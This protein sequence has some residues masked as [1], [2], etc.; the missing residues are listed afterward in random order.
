MFNPLD[1]N[2]EFPSLER[3]IADFWKKN[4][5]QKKYLEKNSSS[6]KKFSFLDGPIT[7]NNPMGVH[8]AW[9]RTYKDVFQRFHNLL[10]DK[11]RFQNGFDCQ[12]LWVEVEVEKDLGFKTKKDIESYGIA[13]F[14]QA[15]KDRANK[16]AVIQTEQSKRLGYFMDWGNDYITMSN[17]NNYAIWYFLKTCWQ[18][19]FLYKGRDSVPWCPRCGTA[20][21]Q[22]EISTEEYGELTHDSIFFELPLLSK[23][24]ER[25]LVWTTTPWTLPANVAVAINPELEYWQVKGDSG[26]KYWLVGSRAKELFGENTSPD[27]KELG[28]FL[29]GQKYSAP[30]DSLP[31]VQTAFLENPQTFHTVIASSDLV[32]AD[33]GTG[34][35]HIAPG[36]GAEDFELGKE[37]NLPVLSVIDESACYLEGLGDLSGKNAKD[38]P[39]L[40]LKHP[41]LQVKVGDLAQDYIFS[42]QPFTHRYP[43]CW[44]CKEELV[45]RVVDEWYIGM[46]RVDPFDDQKRTLRQQII[47]STNQVKTWLPEFGLSRELDWLNNMHDWLISKKRYWGLALPIWECSCGHFEV[48][49]SYEELKERA[50]E[51]WEQFDGKSPHRPFIDI[52]KVN[53][54]KCGEPMSR[55]LDVGNPWLDAGIVGFSTLKYFSD[56]QYWQE[57]FPA[58]LV[59]ECFPGQFRNWFYSLLAMSTVLERQ[60]PFKALVGHASVKDEHGEEMHKSK[61][62]AIWFD[63]A[64][65]KMGAD[66]MRWI[67]CKQNPVLD[68]HFGYL[69]A[70]QTRR[71]FFLILW[72]CY[73]F[74]TTYTNL[75]GFNNTTVLSDNLS[76]LDRWL[77]SRLENAVTVVGKSLST[78]DTAQAISILEDFVIN[79]FSTWYI[80]LSRDRVGPSADNQQDKD[81][82]YQTTYYVLLNLLKILSPFIPFLTEFL[83]QVIK[84]EGSKV[85]IHLEDWPVISGYRD[86]SLEEATSTARR[87][88]EQGR[89][90]RSSAGI[91]LK[92]PLS[93][94]TITQ[95]VSAKAHILSLAENL[96]I[97]ETLKK[98]LNVK[99]VEFAE[100]DQEGI[101][102][103]INL[104][105]ALVLEGRA[106]ELIREIQSARKNLGCNFDDYVSVTYPPEWEDVIRSD[107]S[108]YIK[109]QA[110]VGKFSAGLELLVKVSS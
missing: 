51:G 57:W 104:T 15:C 18:K 40:I 2:P 1:S 3:D 105:D 34:L 106:R 108:D 20:I 77:L 65:E 13:E 31:L 28:S 19:G 61:G 56:R 27:K 58:D 72:N 25:L 91:K 49:G 64:V 55:V 50:I 94:V 110:L 22:H 35:V 59:T 52:V 33:E 53:C 80:R 16:Y 46:D 89:A 75:D 79:D 82:F 102:L 8:H 69:L 12:G 83:W 38:A 100:A 36:C 6:N 90:A 99:A 41:L 63:D 68:L 98:E 17:E 32:K 9:G 54:P 78:Y 24:N 14:V 70:D 66:I 37:E 45:W 74:F 76:S 67:Y 21:S 30:F 60:A 92:Q 29:V 84:P 39:E 11:Q 48:I 88:V 62:N 81:S 87:L 4:G 93:K 101:I 26:I 47:D 95:I 10:G 5:I 71:Q 7:A 85:S 109:R 86:L 43:K 44:R 73:K 23:E 107:Y 96:E 97:Q 103:D 42:I